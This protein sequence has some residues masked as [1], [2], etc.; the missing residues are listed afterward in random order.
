M[1]GEVA[2]LKGRLAPVLRQS[3]QRVAQTIAC[4]TES[5]RLGVLAQVTVISHLDLQAVP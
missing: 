5:C 2:F 3:V 1:W 4:R